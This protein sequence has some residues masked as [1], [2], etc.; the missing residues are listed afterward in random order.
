LTSLQRP[1]KESGMITAAFIIGI[2]IL[3]MITDLP[4]LI[5]EK[6][7]SRLLIIYLFFILSGIILGILLDTTNPPG[8]PSTLITNMVNFIIGSN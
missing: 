3:I 6:K 7:K 1:D 8:N 5:S 4:Y 2:F